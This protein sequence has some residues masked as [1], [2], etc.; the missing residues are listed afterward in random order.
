M[1]M[2]F[3]I[4][5]TPLGIEGV[6]WP[7]NTGQESLYSGTHILS[8]GHPLSLPDSRFSM[9]DRSTQDFLGK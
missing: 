3:S 7:L 6:I 5:D 8:S 4:A 1:N 2:G 9:P